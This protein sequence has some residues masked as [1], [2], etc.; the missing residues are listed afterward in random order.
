[1]VPTLFEQTS[2]RTSVG[3][4]RKRRGRREEERVRYSRQNKTR[5]PYASSYPPSSFPKVHP[6]TAMECSDELLFNYHDAVIY[7]SDLSL[8][9]SPTA[10]LN[11][12][13]INF[14]LTRLQHRRREDGSGNSV[15]R[16]D[17]FLD[18]YVLSINF[19]A[20]HVFFCGSNLLFI[21]MLL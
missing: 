20:C 19:H 10:W 1:M 14:Y 16:N 11:D 12:A 13:C 4:E 3:K 18:P 2:L 5:L 6:H 9:D 17:L 15:D 8:L 7:Q 21:V